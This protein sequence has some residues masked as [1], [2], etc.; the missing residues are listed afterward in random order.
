MAARVDVAAAELDGVDDERRDLVQRAPGPASRR[1]AGGPRRRRRSTPRR[2]RRRAA[3]SPGRTRGGRRGPPGRSASC[4]RSASTSRLPAHRSP[5][6]RAGGSSARA[7]AVEPVRHAEPLEAGDGVARDG[8][9]VAGEPGQREQALG[10]V[11]LGPRRAR[12]VGEAPA[13]RR[14]PV[15]AAERAPAP[16]GA[17]GRGLGP[18]R[19]PCDRSARRRRSTPGRGTAG[20]S[21]VPSETASTSGTGDGLG[22]AQPAEAGRLGGEEPGGWVRVG[23]G[24]HAP[25]V[26][27]VES[28]RLGDVAAPHHRRARDGAGERPLH[29]GSQ[30]LHERQ[31]R[32]RARAS[33]GVANYVD[34]AP[35]GT[36]HHRR[37]IQQPRVRAPGV[38]QVV[39]LSKGSTPMARTTRAR[40]LL[41]ALLAITLV[42]GACSSDD[43]EPER[44]RRRRADR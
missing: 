8:A 7:E 41:A 40:H 24:E 30:P 17:G 19:A 38:D 29:R 1:R 2:S 21:G 18:A 25:A 4:A 33:T 14:A 12:L 27:Q 44:Q 11:E 3:S 31:R 20:S 34:A 28:V 32:S 35:G 5:C 43:D 36:T 22:L 39:R 13:A 10:G 15:L 37:A 26:G 6:R 23:L 9:G 16:P 42:G